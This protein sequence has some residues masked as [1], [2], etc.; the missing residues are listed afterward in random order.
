MASELSSLRF[1]TLFRAERSFTIRYSNAIAKC[2]LCGLNIG[3]LDIAQLIYF[4]S[5]NSVC[6]VSVAF[7]DMLCKIALFNRTLEE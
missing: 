6:V 2:S 5:R 4:Q 3:N 7:S 1:N